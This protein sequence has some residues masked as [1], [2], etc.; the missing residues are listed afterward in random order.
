M[1]TI[2]LTHYYATKLLKFNS[3]VAFIFNFIIVF[4][5]SDIPLPM[6]SILLSF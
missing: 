3:F 1:L 6:M 5:Q 2:L 4:E